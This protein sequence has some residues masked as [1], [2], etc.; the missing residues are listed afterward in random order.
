MHKHSSTI[1]PFPKILFH[2]IIRCRFKFKIKTISYASD[3]NV[4]LWAHFFSN[5]MS[6]DYRDR[7]FLHPP[8]DQDSVVTQ[9]PGNKF[10]FNFLVGS[11]KKLGRIIGPGLGNFFSLGITF[12]RYISISTLPLATLLPNVYHHGFHNLPTIFPLFYLF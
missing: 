9:V 1:P 6:L 3:A 12:T 5:W 4:F 8:Y 10:L 11:Y 2:C 7:H